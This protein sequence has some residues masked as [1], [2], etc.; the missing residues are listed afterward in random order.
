MAAGWTIDEVARLRH[1]AETQRLIGSPPPG[2]GGPLRI[3]AE[4]AQAITSADAALVEVPDG[5]ELTLRAATGTMTG[6]AG[7]R[8]KVANTISGR[9][10]RLG[11]SMR[12]VDT[13]YDTRVDRAH[14][15]RFGIRSMVLVPVI[16]RDSAVAVLKVVSIRPDHFGEPDVEVLQELAGLIACHVT[17]PVSAAPASD[18]PD[19]RIAAVPNRA[20]L[21]ECL[22]QAGAAADRDATTLAVFLI[23]LAGYDQPVDPLLRVTAE[24]LGRITR[25]GDVLARVGPDFVLVCRDI[26]ETDAYGITARISSAVTRATERC[27]DYAQVTAEVGMAWRDEGQRTPA[28]LL[29]AAETALAQGNRRCTSPNSCQR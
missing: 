17:S 10:L 8:L 13:E 14:C 19:G 9:C 5:D 1:I 22:E 27:A 4:Q 24:A 16:H 6:S 3:V 21:L 15:R 26:R 12:C 23:R 18:P 25:G 7:T 11:M 28:A 20:R 29:A 2:T